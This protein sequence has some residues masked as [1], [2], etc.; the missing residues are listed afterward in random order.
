MRPFRNLKVAL[1]ADELTRSC[2][3]RECQVRDLTPLNHHWLFRFWKPDLLLVESAWQGVG[4]AWKF[5]IAAYPE[6]PF[7]SN[8]ALRKVV[9]RARARGIPTVFWNKE[10][11]VHF[12]RFIESASLFEHVFTVD[13]NRLTDYHAVMG[14][15]ASVNTLM[16][17]VQPAL[18]SF[19]GFAFLHHQA[20]F[21]GSYSL[22]L[23][24]RRRLWQDMAFAAASHSGLGLAV[25]DRN[26]G[27][28]AAHYR[29]P[30]LPGQRVRPAVSHANTARVYKDYLVSLNVNTVDDSPTMFSR[31]L[32]EILACG[33]VAVTA[34]ALSV[35][36]LF[37]DYCHVV[38]CEEETLALFERLRL[39]PEPEDLERAR[40]GA[41]Y[42]LA[43][44]TWR[45][46]LEQIA[47]VVGL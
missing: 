17:A 41:E 21:V 40:A 20:N 3:A 19:T 26:S 42:V 43:H 14:R 16:F 23:H 22:H 39:G 6:F 32:I 33:G 7:R 11:G 38:G 8:A 1:V 9:G 10:D 47:S 34:P 30:D 5:K 45:H 4:D 25:F 29:Y 15:D 36:A 35:N 18:H 37:R 46:R 44:H 2:I 27:R 24:D 12:R 28:Q 31:R 13:A